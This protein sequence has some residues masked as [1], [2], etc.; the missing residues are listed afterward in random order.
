[1]S[2]S[3]YAT[4]NFTKELKKLTKKYP[5]VKADLKKLS[6]SLKQ[7]PRQGNPLGGSCY[8]V[9]MPI[10]SKG[11]GKSGGSRVITHIKVT[12]EAIFLLSIYDKSDRSTLGRNEID[13]LLD[14]IEVLNFSYSS[15]N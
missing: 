15:G 7:S 4:D 9:R 5:S 12:V 2:Y 6:D 11:R 13:S 8:K 14:E 3:I 1:M 10:T